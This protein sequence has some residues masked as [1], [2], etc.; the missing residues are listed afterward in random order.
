[1]KEH[2][3]IYSCRKPLKCPAARAFWEEPEGPQTAS[4]IP[5]SAAVLVSPGL[6]PS[7]GLFSILQLSLP[8]WPRLRPSSGSWRV[9]PWPLST[10]PLAGLISA[11]RTACS[12]PA[13]PSPCCSSVRAQPEECGTRARARAHT[14]T[15]DALCI[16]QKSHSYIYRCTFH[17]FL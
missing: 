9:R 17:T 14:H 11:V 7:S 8:A 16:Y 2:K 6:L 15:H 3:G 13:S 1:M 5:A 4:I 12:L 10:G